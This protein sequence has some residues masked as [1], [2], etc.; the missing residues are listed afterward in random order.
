MKYIVYGV[1]ELRT[2]GKNNNSVIEFHTVA[3]LGVLDKRNGFK[4]VKFKVWQIWN[5]GTDSGCAVEGDLQHLPV[6]PFEIDIESRSYNNKEF[7]DL[8]MIGKHVDKQLMV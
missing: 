8:L 3:P 4:G 6:I 2:V 1:S 7:V 5:P